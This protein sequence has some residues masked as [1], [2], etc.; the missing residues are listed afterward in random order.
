MPREIRPESVNCAP[1]PA[2]SALFADLPSRS[3]FRAEVAELSIGLT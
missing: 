1:I 3:F 2:L